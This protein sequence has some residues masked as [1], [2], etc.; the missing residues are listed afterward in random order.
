MGQPEGGQGDD[1]EQL[2]DGL[3]AAGWSSTYPTG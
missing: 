1:Q 3:I 2:S